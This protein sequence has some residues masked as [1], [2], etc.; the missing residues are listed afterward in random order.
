MEALSDEG[1]AATAADVIE[2]EASHDR[3]DG[4]ARGVQHEP[5]L[6]LDDHPDHQ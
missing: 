2:R 1:V 3:S 6:V 4:G 5:V